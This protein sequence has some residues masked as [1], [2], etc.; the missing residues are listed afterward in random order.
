MITDDGCPVRDW[1]LFR[2]CRGC[3]RARFS[4]GSQALS[5]FLVFDEAFKYLL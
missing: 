1:T 2:L 3:L 4:P 5:I